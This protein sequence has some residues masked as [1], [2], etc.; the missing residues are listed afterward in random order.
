MSIRSVFALSF[1]FLSFY[2]CAMNKRVVVPAT[3]TVSVFGAC[4]GVEYLWNRFFKK[5][6]SN[7][8]LQRRLET[9]ESR[10]TETDLL[11]RLEVLEALERRPNKE[12]R[13]KIGKNRR[14]RRDMKK[15]ETAVKKNRELILGRRSVT[16]Y[17]HE[18]ITKLEEILKK[19]FSQQDIKEMMHRRG[20]SRTTVALDLLELALAEDDE[21]LTKKEG[22]K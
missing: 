8:D 20:Q 10:P 5:D 15:M 14:T 1:S 17:L 7:S 11:K 2:S 13:I 19:Q 12:K 21:M 18:R 22:E 9:L 3:V 4:K 16:D 6:H